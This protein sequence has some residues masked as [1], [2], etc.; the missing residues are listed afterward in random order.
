MK[1]CGTTRFSDLNAIIVHHHH[2]S[3]IITLLMKHSENLWQEQKGYL[4]GSKNWMVEVIEGVLIA[5]LL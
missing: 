2:H 4:G 1:S 3:E 5:L